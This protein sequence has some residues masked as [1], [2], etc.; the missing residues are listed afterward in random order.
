[1]TCWSWDRQSSL[2][3]SAATLTGSTPTVVC[4]TPYEH[5]RG[6][7]AGRTGYYAFTL[8]TRPALVVLA[9]SICRTIR[10]GDRGSYNAADDDR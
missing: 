10:R 4:E 8:S 1:M 9:P 3:R 5:A 2:E 7:K 6:V